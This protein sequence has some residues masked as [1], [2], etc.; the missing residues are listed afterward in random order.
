LPKK[1]L[2]KYNSTII[3]FRSSKEGSLNSR[4]TVINLNENL[5]FVPFRK[6]RV[7]SGTRFGSTMGNL[8]SLLFKDGIKIFFTEYAKLSTR[9]SSKRLK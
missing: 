1:L 3:S 8:A 6:A 9:K 2:E 5:L 7:G 4:K